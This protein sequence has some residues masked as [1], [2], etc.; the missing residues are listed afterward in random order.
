MNPELIGSNKYSFAH[1]WTCDCEWFPIPEWFLVSGRVAEVKRHRIFCISVC[2]HFL[3]SLPYS[4]FSRDG[5]LSRCLL[6]DPAV[7]LLVQVLSPLPLCTSPSNCGFR[8]TYEKNLLLLPLPSDSEAVIL[9]C[10]DLLFCTGPV[11]SFCVCQSWPR[12]AFGFFAY[13]TNLLLKPQEVNLLSSFPV[14]SWFPS[15][16]VYLPEDRTLN[17]QSFT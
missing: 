17:F 1:S 4:M 14:P 5:F 3:L 13:H 6:G 15:Q 8:N 12:N 16:N 10:S 9:P 7:A 2:E 11:R